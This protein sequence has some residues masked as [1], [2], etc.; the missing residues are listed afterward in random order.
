V[1]KCVVPRVVGFTLRKAKTRIRSHHCAVGRVTTKFS[2][3]KKKDRVL[4]QVP[5]AGRHLKRGAR[6]NLVL[7]K[8]PRRR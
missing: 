1:V 6:V 8:G 3:R 7:G 5:K 4:A 2:T